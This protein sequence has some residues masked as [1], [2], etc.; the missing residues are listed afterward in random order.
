MSGP[1]RAVVPGWRFVPGERVV[2]PETEAR[3]LKVSRVAPGRSVVLL[4][5]TGG[6]AAAVL[7][8]DGR[9]ALVERLLPPKGEPARR[10]EVLLA[11]GEPARI[12]WAVEKGTE[13]GA[14]A[15]F[16]VAAARSQRAHVAAA[17]AK[18][19]RLRRIAME[20]VKQCD[21]TVVPEVLAPRPLSI[22]VGSLGGRL[23]VARPG[24]SPIAPGRVPDGPLS[25]A[26]GPEGGFD[27]SE[28]ELLDAE[29]AIPFGLG[30]RVLRLE[31]AVVATLSRLAGDDD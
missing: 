3:H 16:F 9:E 1:P 21:R 25:V 31:T 6:R 26:V 20:A 28:E 10:V 17:T 23:L 22:V 18:I 14:A 29:G 5:G 24:A 12:E 13:C 15:F 27:P 2:L 30:S 8:R 19:D 4:D 7:L 11:V